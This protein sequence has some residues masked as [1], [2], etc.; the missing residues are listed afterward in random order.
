M[1]TAVSP[2]ARGGLEKQ[3]EGRKLPVSSPQ[4]TSGKVRRESGFNPGIFRICQSL[5][6]RGTNRIRIEVFPVQAKIRLII[7]FICDS[8]SCDIAL[9]FIDDY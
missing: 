2:V 5:A 4:Q 7:M 6:L 3:E 8:I 9:A 1:I